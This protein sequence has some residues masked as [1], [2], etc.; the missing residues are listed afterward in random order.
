MSVIA[1]CR[2]IFTGSRKA[3]SKEELIDLRRQLTR[4]VK[5]HIM[6][7]TP[8][9]MSNEKAPDFRVFADQM[10]SAPRGKDVA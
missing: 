6:H 2:S 5:A 7:I 8:S 1:F 10:D 3:G 4:N 9:E